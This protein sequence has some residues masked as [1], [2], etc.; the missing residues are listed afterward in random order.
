[1]PVRLWFLR[2]NGRPAGPFQPQDLRRLAADGR[3]GPNDR[4]RRS[5]D[6]KWHRAKR[7]VGLFDRLANDRAE[8]PRANRAG[9]EP[10]GSTIR[11]F[12]DVA[13]ILRSND[14]D[15]GRLRHARAVRSDGAISDG[16][17][18]L[19]IA[20]SAAEATRPRP[21]CTASV[22]CAAAVA[23]LMIYLA[24]A[25]LA[26]RAA[27]HEAMPGVAIREPTVSAAAASA[28]EAILGRTDPK[29]AEVT[30]LE[31]LRQTEQASETAPAWFTFRGEVR[32]TNR[33]GAPVEADFGVIVRYDPR[34][35]T[36]A[37]ELVSL[38]GRMVTAQVEVCGHARPA[39]FDQLSRELFER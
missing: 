14:L 20:S 3:L 24:V 31:L 21:I 17:Q 13:S 5:G 11:E 19:Q 12:N 15:Q 26:A 22:V 36:Y 10:A 2:V 27:E 37:P 30:S 28:R 38:A 29:T 23:T 32:W 8:P 33:L 18:A 35:T 7:I 16:G 25:A 4:L 34:L 39:E 9:P 1:M 6:S